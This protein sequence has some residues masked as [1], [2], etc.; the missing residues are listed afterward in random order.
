MLGIILTLLL[1][2]VIGFASFVPIAAAKPVT[3][4][5]Q[6]PT[7]NRTL[8]LIVGVDF[9]FFSTEGLEVKTVFIR[10]GP[11][12]I[13][14]L[15]GGDV[16]HRSAGGF[17]RKENRYGSVPPHGRPAGARDSPGASRLKTG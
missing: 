12:A 15:V 17:E 6:T 3:F 7:L 8:P 10:G 16:G 14:A 1:A 9:G 5:Y 13:A 11:T 2:W 4:A